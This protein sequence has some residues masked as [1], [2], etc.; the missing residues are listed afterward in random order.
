MCLKIG[1]FRLTKA[2]YRVHTNPIAST[3]PHRS[4]PVTAFEQNE[5]IEHCNRL[6]NL[7]GVT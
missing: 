6:S 5:N 2:V 3:A 1:E 4:N 7:L